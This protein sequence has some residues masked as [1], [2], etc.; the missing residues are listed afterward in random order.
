MKVNSLG[1]T[2]VVLALCSTAFAASVV[3][4]STIDGGGLRTTSASYTMDGSVG[5]IGGISSAASDTAKHGYIGQLYDV[6]SVSVTGTPA[7]VNETSTS[8][9]SGTATMDDATVAALTGLDISWNTPAFPISSINGSG[10]ATMSVVCQNTSGSFGGSYL[11]VLGSGSLLVQDSLPDNYGAYAGDTLPDS[12]QVQYFGLPPNPNAA[13]N[14]DVTGTGQNNLF[15]YVAG[16]DPTNPAS[17]FVLQIANVNG[18]PNQENLIFNPLATG[19]TY[20]T[21]FTTNL[22]GTAYATLTGIGGPT[23]NGNEVTVTDLSAVETQK[24]YRV[25]ISLP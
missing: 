16:L 24:F 21:Q 3:T 12:W 15:K 20:T 1:L 18:Q 9:L 25:H 13:T 5:S 6:V 19:R 17:V 10:L 22:V 7:S 2:V 4:T 11:G 8:Q 14:A 23:T